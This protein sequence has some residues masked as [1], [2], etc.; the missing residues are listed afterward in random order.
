MQLRSDKANVLPI[1]NVHVEGRV[2]GTPYRGSK[3][4][5]KPPPSPDSRAAMAA[6]LF[7]AMI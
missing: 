1:V 7:A 6:L 5:I 2:I 3:L 4:F